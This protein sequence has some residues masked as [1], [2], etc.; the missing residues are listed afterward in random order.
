MKKTITVSFVEGKVR[1]TPNIQAC[2]PG[3]LVEWDFGEIAEGGELQIEFHE[4]Q[5]L[6]STKRLSSEPINPFT[7]ALVSV[8]GR[9]EGEV[10]TDVLAGRRF[11]YRFFLDGSPLSWENPIDALHDFGGLDIPPPPPRG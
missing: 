5:E 1:A 7:A 10:R 8:P 11:M 4:V 2:A 9:I 6:P 3:D